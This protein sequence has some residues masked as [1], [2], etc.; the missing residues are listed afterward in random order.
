MGLASM[1]HDSDASQEL[2]VTQLVLNFAEACRALVPHMDR[3]LVSWRDGQQFDNWDRVAEALF[4]SLVVEPCAFAAK[5]L[6][7]DLA[8]RLSRYG[9]ASPY[10]PKDSAVCVVDGNR[11]T[12]LLR[13]TSDLQPFD[14]V[15]HGPDVAATMPIENADFAFIAVDENGK[16]HILRRIDLRVA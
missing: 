9:F 12:R 1:G 5:S 3:A 4:Q 2:S 11:P 10:N 6:T 14:T 15:V 16:S 8:L 7:G 13:L